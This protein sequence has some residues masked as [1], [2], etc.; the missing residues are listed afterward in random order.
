[1]KHVSLECTCSLVFG[2]TDTSMYQFELELKSSSSIGSKG[3]GEVGQLA[4]TSTKDQDKGSNKYSQAL[5][6]SKYGLCS[7]C[8]FL[9]VICNKV[10]Y[11]C[12]KG[13]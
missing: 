7:L 9:I 3:Q 6:Q 12:A 1:M 13:W 8:I 5:W 2:D 10:K 11:I 4:S